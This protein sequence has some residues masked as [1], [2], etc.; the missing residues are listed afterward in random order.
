[1]ISLFIG[2]FNGV[3]AIICFKQGVENWAWTNLVL[4]ACNIAVF[5]SNV[6]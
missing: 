6:L 4:S 5:L 1:M 2:T 3:A